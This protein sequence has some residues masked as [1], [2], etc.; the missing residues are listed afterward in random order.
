MLPARF[1]KVELDLERNRYPTRHRPSGVAIQMSN[2]LVPVFIQSLS[3]V[4]ELDITDI[5]ALLQTAQC[6]LIH[7]LSRR[8]NSES[9]LQRPAHDC[10]EAGLSA[11]KRILTNCCHTR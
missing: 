2:Y 10:R 5:V 8:F 11:G 3:P 7:L 6:E 4:E 1:E 9:Y